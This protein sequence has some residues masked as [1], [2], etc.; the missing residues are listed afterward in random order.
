PR[1]GGRPDGMD[2]VLGAFLGLRRAAGFL[3][4]GGRSA[5]RRTAGDPRGGRHLGGGGGRRRLGPCPYATRGGRGRRG[6]PRLGRRGNAAVRGLGPVAAGQ[7]ALVPT[8]TGGAVGEP[9]AAVDVI[10]TK[11]D[12][13]TLSDAQIDWVVDAYTRGVVADE[14]MAALAMAILLRG[15]SPAEISRWTTAMIASGERLDLSG[16][17]RPTVDKHSTGGVG[18]K[19]T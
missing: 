12:G 8:R 4:W 11:R 17:P 15:M 9:F 18:D 1:L 3:R 6:R 13:G 19:I 2:R 5:D 14:Q 16:V 7:R 10:A